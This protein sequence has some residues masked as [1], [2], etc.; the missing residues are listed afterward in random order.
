M[1]LVAKTESTKEPE[2]VRSIV[3]LVMRM[4]PLCVVQNEP[5]TVRAP[6]HAAR[7]ETALRLRTI[8]SMQVRISVAMQEQVAQGSIELT[9]PIRAVRRWLQTSIPMLML[10]GSVGTGKSVAIAEAGALCKGGKCLSPMRLLREARKEESPWMYKTHMM[11]LDDLGSEHTTPIFMEVL[12][13]WIDMRSLYGRTL[14]TTN[15]TPSA[16]ALRYGDRV[17][18]RVRSSGVVVE[19]SGASLRKNAL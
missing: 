14:I 15:L 8:E 9:R 11:A 5:M 6:E 19:I 17:W 16:F 2:P 4:A 3:D 7:R 10:C 12:Q 13:E 1:K 18:D